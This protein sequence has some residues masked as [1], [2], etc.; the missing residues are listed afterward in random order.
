MNDEKVS[1]LPTIGSVDRATDYLYII[2]SSVGTS[3]KV[4]VNGALGIIG[5]PLGTTDTQSVTNKT[6]DN[7]NILTIR[8]DRL[9]LQ[10]NVDVTKQ[11]IFQL[12]GITTGT[13]RTY[14]L[15]NASVTLAS[16]TGNE[17]FTNKTLTS[18]VINTATISNPTLTTDAINEY[19]VANGVNIDGLVIKDALLPA[20]NIQP[21]N[22]VSG[23]GSSWVWQSWVPTW[24]N[25]SIG[26]GVIQYAKY[27]QIGKTLH[28]RIQFSFGSTTT[29]SGIIGFSLP[30]TSNI[31]LAD[32]NDFPLTSGQFSDATGARW[33]PA[34][35]FGTTSRLDL[36]YWDLNSNI[37]N[38]SSTAPFTWATNDLIAISGTYEVA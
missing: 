17:I 2:D 1:L 4:L 7:S 10:D 26:D 14:T 24:N 27:I 25:L 12:S 23:T 18:P 36:Y 19:T 35:A 20:G 22:L 29:I 5:N 8:D 33:N 31:D 9:T 38:T 16:L 6:L 34:V 21:L 32:G 15:P 3:N 11:A 13:T 37:A 30:V 28:Y